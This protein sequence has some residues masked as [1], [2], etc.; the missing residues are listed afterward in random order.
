M[1]YV[2]NDS[3]NFE[4]GEPLWLLVLDVHPLDLGF[5]RAL[6]RECDHALD[7][8][9]VALEDG[10]D[11]PVVAVRDPAGHPARARLLLSGVAEEHALHAA[12]HHPPLS[13][14]HAPEYS[15]PTAFNA[16]SS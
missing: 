5:A 10:F 8:V 9:R 1:G 11:R 4:A 16:S 12:V 13:S 7:R 2:R 3:A 14:A 6:A 15:R